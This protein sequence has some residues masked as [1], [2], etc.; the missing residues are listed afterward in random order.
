M[1]PEQPGMRG[2][3]IARIVTFFSFCF[4]DV[5]YPCALVSRFVTVGDGPDE[6]T[7]M[8]IVQPDIDEEGDAV[9][10]IVHIDCILRAAH[11]IGIS[12]SHFIPTDFSFHDSLDVFRAFYVNK[13]ADHHTF[14]I[15]F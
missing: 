15:A 13:F 3:D 1:R 9:M 12:G 5:E 4:N 8:W 2:L 6:D 14:D 7:G 10:I 11:L